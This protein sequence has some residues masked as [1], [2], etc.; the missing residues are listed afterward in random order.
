MRCFHLSDHSLRTANETPRL[1][2]CRLTFAY[3]C[4]CSVPS[5][6]HMLDNL[7]HFAWRM[8]SFIFVSHV[9]I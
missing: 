5:G 3:L 7:E 1:R 6:Y 8:V 9:A 4:L 2:G